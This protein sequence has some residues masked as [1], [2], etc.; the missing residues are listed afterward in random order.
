MKGLIF[1]LLIV[2][3]FFLNAQEKTKR[4]YEMS[5]EELMQIKITSSTLTKTDIRHSPAAITLITQDMI[6]QSGAR[7]LMELFDIYVPNLQWIKH[8]WEA[9]HLGI[10]GI[11]NDREDKYLLLINGRNMNEKTHIGAHSEKDTPLLG[12]IH[13][14]EVIRGPASAIYGPGAISMVINIITDTPATFEGT[15]VISSIGAIEEFA[16]FELKHGFRLNNDGGF[17]LYFG[18]ANYD[19]ATSSNAPEFYSNTARDHFGTL[20][21]SGNPVSYKTSRDGAANRNIPDIK[22]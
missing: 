20:Q 9:E 4:I 17:L 12:G 2:G 7:S 3:I 18:I 5:Y 16:S 15:E 22:I 8:H 6:R 13:R 19:G 21:T 14:I 10:R 1:S 11:I